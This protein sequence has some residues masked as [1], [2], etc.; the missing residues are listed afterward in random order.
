VKALQN[1]KAVKLIKLF[2]PL[3]FVLLFFSCRTI[4]TRIYDIETPLLSENTEI[5]IVQIS[6]F[7]SVFY[8]EK[9]EKLIDK[10]KSEEPDLIVLTGDIFDDTVS[11]RGTQLLLSGIY[12]IAPIYFVTGN[13]EYRSGNMQKIKELL[14]F[15]EIR[16]LSDEYV[17]ITIKGN[18]IVLAGIDDPFKSLYENDNYNQDLAMEVSFREL[19]YVN[20]FKILL[21][22]RPERI[23]KYKKFSFN[24]ILSGHTHGGQIRLPFLFINGLYAPDQGL[25]PKYAGGLYRHDDL[26]HIVSRGLFKHPLYPRIFNPPE[27]VVIKIKSN[28]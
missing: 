3:Y 11:A 12:G 23:E 16:I 4:E 8:G 1:K 27:L 20:K 19:D 6:D 18:E 25:F 13:H 10:V 26:I 21:A 14:W 22:H 2:F 5:T 15:H 24:L 9:Q 28:R 17:I 7:H